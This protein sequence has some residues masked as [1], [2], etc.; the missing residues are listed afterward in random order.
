MNQE[1]FEEAFPF[2]FAI[3][4]NFQDI[5]FIP[6]VDELEK[7]EQGHEV[8][9]HEFEEEE[10][11]EEEQG[12]EVEEHEFEEEEKEEE[13]QVEEEEHEYEDEDEEE[14]EEEEEENPIIDFQEK[15]QEL[16]DLFSRTKENEKKVRAQTKDYLRIINDLEL[17]N[18]DLVRTID[19]LE[20]ENDKKRIKIEE[21][22]V[23]KNKLAELVFQQED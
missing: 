20:E 5:T 22:S 21:F 8:E 10:K 17:R 18:R 7:E 2:R 1:F 19:V 23:L 9:E 6:V 11:D 16:S 15:I 12:H 14:E 13:E 4:K 3:D